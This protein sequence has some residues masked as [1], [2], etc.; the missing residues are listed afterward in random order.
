M[1]CDAKDTSTRALSAARAACGVARLIWREGSR[2]CLD[3]TGGMRIDATLRTLTLE[4]I[5]QGSTGKPKINDTIQLKR[6]AS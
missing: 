6:D 5:Q 4:Y 2:L 3:G 1:V